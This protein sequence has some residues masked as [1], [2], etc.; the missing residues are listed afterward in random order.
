MTFYDNNLFDFTIDLTFQSA[1]LEYLDG[2]VD[3]LTKERLTQPNFWQADLLMWIH[4]LRSNRVLTCPELVRDA[5]SLSMSLNLTND[6]TITSLNQTW[7]N[8]KESTDV[9]SFPIIDDFIVLQPQQC[10]ELGDIFVSVTT[11]QRQARQMN[12]DLI[13]ELRWLVSHGLL[14][15]MGW[16][17]PDQA[18]LDEMLDFQQKLLNMK[19]IL[20]P[21]CDLQNK[22]TI[23]PGL[24]QHRG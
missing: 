12:H 2:E 4:T 16:D 18:R 13:M 1:S 19:D 22:T 9:L 3:N 23:S 11:A 10:I 15:L 24:K 17:H 7:L 8:K 14:H 21:T 20:L 6:S 5:K